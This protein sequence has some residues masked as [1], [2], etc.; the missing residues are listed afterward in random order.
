MIALLLA[1]ALLVPAAARADTAHSTHDKT[2]T[3][4]DRRMAI[5]SRAPTR[6]RDHTASAT[7]PGQVSA[8]AAA[9]IVFAGTAF[10]LAPMAP[11]ASALP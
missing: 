4:A 8:Y 3:E 10:G 9:P 6:A 5:L 1:T 7:K 11:D 2:E